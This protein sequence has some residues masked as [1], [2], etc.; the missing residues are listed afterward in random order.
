[1][2]SIPPAISLLAS[3]LKTP[4]KQGKARRVGLSVRGFNLSGGRGRTGGWVSDMKGR[5]MTTD[6]NG[7]DDD[8]GG[9]YD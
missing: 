8:D 3:R 6:G 2:P 9:S 4:E 7:D 5:E 1:M